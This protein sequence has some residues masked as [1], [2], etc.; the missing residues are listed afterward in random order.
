ARSAAVAQRRPAL[1]AS[2]AQP[3]PTTAAPSLPASIPSPAEG[4][5]VGGTVT[6]GMSESNGAGTISW[7]LRLDGGATP[8][9]STSGTAST[10]SFNWDA[11]AVTP[12]AHT[13]TLTVQDGAGRT[14]TATRT[15]T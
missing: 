13:L 11:S 2:N 12:G 10:A 7:A 15:V 1:Q 8:I 6:V 5:T 9:F 4:A 3:L 14:A